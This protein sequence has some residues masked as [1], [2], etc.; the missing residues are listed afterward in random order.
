MLHL[1]Y[2]LV[3]AGLRAVKLIFAKSMRAEARALLGERPKR[4]RR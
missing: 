2:A 3:P 4:R 1:A